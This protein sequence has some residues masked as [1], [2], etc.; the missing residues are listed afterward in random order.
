MPTLFIRETRLNKKTTELLDASDQQGYLVASGKDVCDFYCA[1]CIYVGEFS[2]P[3]TGPTGIHVHVPARKSMSGATFPSGVDTQLLQNQLFRYRAFNHDLVRF[4]DFKPS[5]LSPE[6]CAVAQQLGAAVAEDEPLQDELIEV[7][8][9]QDEQ[10]RVDRSSTVTAMVLK[11][12][13]FHCH[14]GNQEKVFVRDLAATVNN[15]YRQQGEPLKISNERLGHL[16]KNLGL[17]TRRLSNAG[18]G[19][20]LDNATRLRAH[21]LSYA[22][23][24]LAEPPACGHCQQRLQV[25]QSQ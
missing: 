9:E 6:S 11:A 21:E 2:E 23:E 15:A 19:L 20:V 4:S 8:T 17:Y 10:A 14:D 18:R 25:Q 5:G 1:K 3:V 13:L 7:L 12:V 16:L 24:V 22:N